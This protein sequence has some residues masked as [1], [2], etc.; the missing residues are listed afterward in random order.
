MNEVLCSTGALI[1]RPNNRNYRLL[2]EL[3][4]QLDCDGF[5][6]M[7]YDTWYDQTEELTDY[8]CQRQFHIPVVHCEKGIG[9]DISRGGEENLGN[10]V[11]RFD[12]NCRL[13]REIGASKLVVHLWDGITSDR[14]M[15]SNLSAYR[16]L[17]GI[18]GAYGLELLVENVVCN[19]EDPMRHW[20]SLREVY[21]DIRFVFDTKM[22]AFHQ[23][24]GLLYQGEYAWLWREGHLA[25]YHVNDYAGGYKDWRNL[26]TLPPGRGHVDFDRFFGFVRETGYQGAFTVEATAFGADGRV[27]TDM[28]N[29]CFADIRRYLG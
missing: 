22:A 15:E 2:E 20:R 8:L 28:L 10:A 3:A 12:V 7:M 29:A 5:E 24:M 17:A 18:A 4:R 25:H 23:Q 13:A 14:N 6:F 27:N 21:P 9:E 1:G 16:E 11:R 19:Q 26:R